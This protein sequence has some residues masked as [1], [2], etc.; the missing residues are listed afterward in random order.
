MDL[1]RV[2][3]KNPHEDS[4]ITLTAIDS[5]TME[6][7]DNYYNTLPEKHK[8]LVQLNRKKISS[9]TKYSN[10]YHELTKKIIELETEIGDIENKTHQIN[11]LL[12]AAPHFLEYSQSSVI[13]P[14]TKLFYNES[15]QNNTNSNTNTEEK[16]AKKARQTTESTKFFVTRDGTNRGKIC[17]EYIKDCIGDGYSLSTKS[18]EIEATLELT[19]KNCGVEKL[20]NPRESYASCPNCGEMSKYQDTQNNKGEYSEEVEVLSPFAYKR[21]NHFKEWISTLVAREGSGPPQEVIDE[22]YR[23]L[24]KDKIENKKD[25]TEERIRGYLK[26]LKHSKLYENIPAIIAKIC[27]VQPPPISPKLEAT[28]ISMFQQI[29]APFDKYSPSKRSNFLSYSYTIRKLLQLL[30]QH[31]LVEKLSLLKSREKLY[32]QDVI[33]KKICK[34]LGWKYFPSL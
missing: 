25:V 18:N 34:D 16:T 21:I 20:T 13:N 33:W 3:K 9:R 29:Q 23:E 15:D 2:S 11:Y 8:L 12:R 17:Q 28:L 10:E 1:S 31:H 32:Q 22:L 4:R 19:C 24:K 27:G 5:K 30:G 7:Y 14:E 6:N 26:K